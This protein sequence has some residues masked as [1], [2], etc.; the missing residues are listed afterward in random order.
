[1]RRPK[2]MT[3]G[4]RL[5][6]KA[7]AACDAALTDERAPTDFHLQTISRLALLHL[8]TCL[9]TSNYANQDVNNFY[10]VAI[11]LLR[12]CVEALTVVDLGLQEPGFSGPR[13][14]K[15]QKGTLSAGELRKCLEDEVWPAYGK[16][17]WS[18]PWAKFFGNLARAVQ[19]YAHYTPELQGWQVKVVGFS[20][21]PRFLANLAP[22]AR[23]PIKTSRILRLQAI[24]TWTLA[25]LVL[26]NRPNSVWPIATATEDLGRALEASKLLWARSDWGTQLMP[27]VM[28]DPELDW[29][30]E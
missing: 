14:E 11:C 6:P 30:D 4:L 26:F 28:Y 19:P 17:L 2:W 1:M 5:W 3:Q 25:R 7:L 12:H 21:G 24:I 23:D 29:Q 20:G 27:H 9:E 15:W 22:R 10:S 13:L 16:G 18:E 8:T